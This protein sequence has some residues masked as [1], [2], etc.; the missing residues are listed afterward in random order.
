[1]WN[2]KKKRNNNLSGINEAAAAQLFAEICDDDDPLESSMEGASNTSC[3]VLILCCA[4]LC[5]AVRVFVRVFVRSVVEYYV[6][7]M[8]LLTVAWCRRR[9]AAPSPWV[10]SGFL[11]HVRLL[12]LSL[13]LSFVRSPHVPYCVCVCV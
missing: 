10:T 6:E 1:M 2:S 8:R 11:T 3:G 5:C 13:S 7:G 4:V 12:P 9:M